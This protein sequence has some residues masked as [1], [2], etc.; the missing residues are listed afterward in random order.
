MNDIRDLL[1]I[2]NEAEFTKESIEIG[3]NF[4]LEIG[5]DLLIE[6][7][8]VDIQDDAII[9]EADDKVLRLLAENGID[10]TE[11]DLIKGNFPAARD[12][13]KVNTQK[14][15][16]NGLYKDLVNSQNYKL[17]KTKGQLQDEDNW[18]NLA[19]GYLVSKGYG[20][21]ADTLLYNMANRLLSMHNAYTHDTDPKPAAES[22]M[23]RIME[24]ITR[25]PMRLGTGGGD[26]AESGTRT[27]GEGFTNT[28]EV[29]DM[30][31][32]SFG[33]AGK[34]TSDDL[35]RAVDEYQS[36]MDNPHKLDV[37]DVVQT[38]MDRFAN[39]GMFIPDVSEAKYQGREVPLG[40]PMA[41][42]VKKSKVYVKGPKG[43]VVKVNFGDKK[44]K[45]KK[46]NPKRRKSFR[47]RHNCKNPGPRWKARYW[48][49][50]AW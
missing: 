38:L 3:D 35:Y 13:S 18:L 34:L 29:A 33:G 1:D 46:S 45:I 11:G 30:I 14:I 8:V 42:D 15:D 26:A 36:M 21:I 37:E 6:S 17:A 4:D 28:E 19:Q 10:V 50:R 22:K 27:L 43:N 16:Y 40:K 48:S 7:Y 25:A 41:G 32:K 31:E 39:R 9:I 44:M 47:A 23:S 24:G 20:N 49:C 5:D 2:I 12:I